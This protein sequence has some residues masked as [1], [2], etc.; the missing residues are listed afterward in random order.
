MLS[1]ISV[2]FEGKFNPWLDRIKSLQR[3][4]KYLIDNYYQVSL[5]PHTVVSMIIFKSLDKASRLLQKR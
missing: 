2:G 4:Q 1:K 5:G 3:D